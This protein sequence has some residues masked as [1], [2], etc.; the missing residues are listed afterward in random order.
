[1]N[2][3]V[4]RNV[5]SNIIYF[6]DLNQFDKFIKQV[7]YCCTPGCKGVLTPVYVKSVGLGG[8]ISINCTCGNQ[9]AIFETI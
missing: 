8:T 3:P 2:A 6:M 4:V 1:M 7:K 5:T 9:G